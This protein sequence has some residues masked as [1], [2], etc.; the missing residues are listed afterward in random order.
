M[1]NAILAATPLT[2]RQLVAKSA[3]LYKQSFTRVILLGIGI[4]F[5]T[6]LPRMIYD[7][8]QVENI[9]RVPLFSYKQL[10]WYLIE[11][12]GLIFFIA[13]LWRMHKISHASD[14]PLKKDFII[15]LRK[16]ASVFIISLLQSLIMVGL[17]AAF[18]GILHLLHDAQL[19]FQR[20]FISVVLTWLVFICQIFLILY[21]STRL[22]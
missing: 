17:L 15:G 1:D 2:Y 18:Y 21:V 19:L 12:I 11:I 8:F 16:I 14:A 6:F 10:Y 9:I 7:L 4:A 20:D 13:I 3:L 22:S 5:F